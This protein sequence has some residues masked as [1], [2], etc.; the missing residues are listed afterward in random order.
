MANT[1]KQAPK[2]P[3][4]LLKRRKKNEQARAKQIKA[5]LASKKKLQDKKRV[6][7]KRAE[8]YV[9]EYRAKAKSE[10]NLARQAKKS[11]N[12]Y[13][14]AESKLAFVMR[15]RGIN[16]V[17]PR[18]RKILQLLR[19]RQI[20]NGVFIKLNKATVQML[21]I[22]EPFITWGY[23]NLKSVRELIYKRGYG[24]V[25]G[26]RIP[27]TDNS[28]IEKVLGSKG[29]ICMEDL[30]H[31]IVTVGPNFKEAANFLW[32]FKLNTP[33]GGWRRKYNHFNDGGDCG[34]RDAQINPLLRNMV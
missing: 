17:H 6:I 8:K 32:P 14:P 28:I 11:G 13:V 23:P 5:N 4:T 1:K 22:A 19:L 24:K 31:E 7:F 34:L 30:I 21:R 18:P 26:R 33:N 12:F 16:G 25:N 20:N 10:I 2:V 29:I 9:K 27:L 15:I 3:E